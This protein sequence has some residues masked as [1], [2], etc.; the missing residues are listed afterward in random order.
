[1]SKRTREQPVWR[2]R[3]RRILLIA[4]FIVAAGALARL[5]GWDISAWFEQLWD[6]LTTISAGY[7]AAAVIAQVVQTT[8]TAFAWYTIL[9]YAYPGELQFRQMLAAYA[10]CVALNNVLPANLGTIV[11]F[12]ML[13]TVMASA[14]FAGLLGGFAVQKIFFTLAGVFVY[15]YLFLTVGGS[16]NIDFSWVKEHPWALLTL[17]AGG[18]VT[19][20]LVL[21]L[22]WPKVLAWWEQ[23]KEGGKVLSHPGVYFGEVFFPEFIAWVSSLCIVGIFLAAYA[24]PVT[25]HTVM[26][27]VG[28]NSISNTLSLTPGGAG[29]NQA[30]NVAALHGVTDSATSAAYSVAQQLVTTAW[31]LLFAIVLL[32][33][34]FGWSGGTALVSESYAEA[35]ARAD[36]Q[37]AARE[38]R[39][40][41]KKA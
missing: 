29:V 32:V 35:K 19:I 21:R 31:S 17:L 36:E 1:V 40:A 16:F 20:Y 2:A 3:A 4:A 24:I 26:T 34:V 13:I 7:I 5:L 9:R 11:M 23:A 33:W 30:L 37:K 18:A 38:A 41:T 12:V 25:F 39:R 14:T 28:S 8:A 6:T 22:F 10:A 15:L 27:V